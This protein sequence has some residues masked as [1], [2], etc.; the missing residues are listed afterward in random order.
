MLK[1]SKKALEEALKLLVKALSDNSQLMKRIGGRGKTTNREIYECVVK[2]LPIDD[3]LILPAAQMLLESF[4]ILIMHEEEIISGSK[5][6][7]HIWY[8]A[9]K[10]EEKIS[11]Q[12]VPLL[13][14][15]ILNN[16]LK[17][18]YV[19]P[20][21]TVRLTLEKDENELF[22][23]FI[24]PVIEMIFGSRRALRKG[25]LITVAF[26]YPIIALTRLMSKLEN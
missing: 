1:I 20:G 11:E 9:L 26:I 23:G 24:E 22:F 25:G 16:D 8:H 6:L 10:I 3:P 14:K 4:G 7:L 12:K 18:Y 17:K 5:V 2:R 19:P 13:S 15:S 21:T